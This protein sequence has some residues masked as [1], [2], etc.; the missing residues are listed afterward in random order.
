MAWPITN[1]EERLSVQKMFVS[2]KYPF[3][4]VDNINPPY[5]LILTNEYKQIYVDLTGIRPDPRTN[6]DFD[7]FLRLKSNVPA[8]VLFE[9]TNDDTSTMKDT[10]PKHIIINKKLLSNIR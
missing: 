3:S 5:G 10:L 7:L 2:P 9:T 6:D 8:F 4:T 1:V